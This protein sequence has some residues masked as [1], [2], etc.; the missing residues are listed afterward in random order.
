MTSGSPDNLQTHGADKASS[1]RMAVFV[2]MVLAGLVWAVYGQVA[3]FDFINL[4]DDAYVGDNTPV[5]DGLTVHGFKWAFY[6]FGNKTHGGNWHP[7]T[8]LSMM[9]D[10]EIHGGHPAGFHLINVILHTINVLLL[11]EFL[12]R[13]TLAIWPSAF[14]AALF[15][16]HPQNVE[17][18]AWITERKGMLS[19][20][21]FMLALL[22]YTGYA[23][24]GGVWRYLGVVVL[25]ALGLMTKPVLVTLPFVLLLLDYWPLRR[26]A[27][28]GRDT[29][30]PANLG[31]LTQRFMVLFA[32]KIPL[33]CMTIASCITTYLSEKDG[34][35]VTSLSVLSMWESTANSLTTYLVYLKNI[36][37]PSG[38]AIPY[39][40]DK[41]A[42]SST[43]AVVAIA[44]LVGTSV[45]VLW[46]R[47]SSPWACVGWFWFAGMLVPVV[48][49]VHVGRE[50]HSDK[51]TYLPSIGIFIAVAFGLAALVRSWPKMRPLVGTMCA[52][53]VAVLATYCFIQ[54]SHWKNSITLFT[55]TL[56][57]MS[58]NDMAYTNRARAHQMNGDSQRAIAD[59]TKALAIRPRMLGRAYYNRGLIYRKLGRHDL[60]IQ[61]FS[62]AIGFHRTGESK[63]G[64]KIGMVYYQRGRTYQDSAQPKKA[65]ADYSAAVRLMPAHASVYW[66]RGALHLQQHDHRSARDDLR[67]AAELAPQDAEIHNA[68]GWL[69]A[70]SPT[71]DVLDGANALKHAGLACEFT[72]WKDGSMLDTLAAAYAADG[73]FD[74]AVQ[75]Q[76]QALKMVPEAARGPLQRRLELYRSGKPYRE[77]VTSD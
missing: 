52:V 56:T 5:M 41:E 47:R 31:D 15:A 6:D 14:V 49:I 57:L 60:A 11:F 72:S 68:L 22:V 67:R 77:T 53:V 33:L 2:C 61:D 62:A 30:E 58:D 51:F 65:L 18:V 26:F 59:Y 4:D 45:L 8:W 75:T 32:E 36:F 16:I 50:S 27:V 12:R 17:S 43:L 1:G 39:L 70:T 48:K 20:V 71:A 66:R 19:T 3:T 7:V 28:A 23:R 34:G 46:R 64:D 40:L 42:I 38:L 74:K 55:H 44:V 54:T 37:W 76:Q 29:I 24:R 21:F 10:V 25:F 63:L 73:Q 9:L 69:L 13:T 35:S